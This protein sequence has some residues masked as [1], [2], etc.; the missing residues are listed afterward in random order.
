MAPIYEHPNRLKCKA[1]I[2]YDGSRFAGWQWQ[3]HCNS[4]QQ[5]L[6]VIFQLVFKQKVAIVGASRTDQGVHANG[7]V[8]LVTFNYFGLE[9]NKVKEIWNR[10]LPKD[11]LIIDLE[12]AN[13][14]FH[15]HQNVLLKTYVYQIAWQKQHPLH[16]QYAW[17][18]PLVKKIDWTIFN[19]WLNLFVGQKDFHQFHKQEKIKPRPTKRNIQKISMNIERSSLGTFT[20][21]TFSA[22]G[23]L[24]YQIRRIVGA[25]TEASIHKN[26][27]SASE[28]KS[29]LDGLVMESSKIPTLC[30]N[31]EGLCLQEIHFD[32][33]IK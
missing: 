9:I 3:E 11:I 20:K 13:D 5:T 10:S 1:I 32:E 24:R 23:F 15:P 2:A 33:K 26:K 14:N 18:Y 31:P 21:I 16:N 12:L 7:Q 29:S 30:A 28:T 22:K 27:F 8:A 4:V 6:I 19:E 25:C 17:N